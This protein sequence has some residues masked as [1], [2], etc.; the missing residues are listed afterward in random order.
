MPR[1]HWYAYKVQVQVPPLNF[2]EGLMVES[3]ESVRIGVSF[4]F[5]LCQASHTENRDS[6]LKIQTS[7]SVPVAGLPLVSLKERARVINLC[8][9]LR[10]L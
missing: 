2:G 7:T 8:A 3:D 1:R 4:I 10:I 9:S 5:S 6:N